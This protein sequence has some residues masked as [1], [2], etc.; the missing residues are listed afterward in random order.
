MIP[1]TNTIEMLA[2]FDARLNLA[3][4]ATSKPHSSFHLLHFWKLWCFLISQLL[5]FTAVINI[6]KIIIRKEQRIKAVANKQS[7]IAV[8]VSALIPCRQ[9]WRHGWKYGWNSTA[10]S[11]TIGAHVDKNVQRNWFATHYNNLSQQKKQIMRFC[12]AIHVLA[13]LSLK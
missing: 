7:L 2:C 5:A 3:D 12:C 6:L 8:V 9:Q 4:T 10:S 13:K 1:K 11:W